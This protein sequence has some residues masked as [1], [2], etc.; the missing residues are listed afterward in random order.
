[1][2]VVVPRVGHWLK[3]IVLFCTQFASGLLL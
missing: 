3:V 1:L 2:D